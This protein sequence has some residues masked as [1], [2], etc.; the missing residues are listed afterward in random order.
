MITQMKLSPKDKITQL[1]FLFH[2][3]IVC[4]QSNGLHKSQA[5]QSLVKFQVECGVSR[6]TASQRVL[7]HFR[8]TGADPDEMISVWEILQE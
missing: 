6:K 3:W 1:S 5:I 2:T 4:C 7:D 8:D